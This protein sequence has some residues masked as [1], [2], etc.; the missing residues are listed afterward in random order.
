ME[1]KAKERAYLLVSVFCIAICL[2]LIFCMMTRSPVLVGGTAGGH[3]PPQQRELS[4]VGSPTSEQKRMMVT[5]E[6]FSKM[7]S[8]YLPSGFPA[9]EIDVQISESGS[10]LLS[11]QVER[12]NIEQYLE[13]NQVSL[14]V[15]QRLLMSMMPKAFEL[16]A[17][18]ACTTSDDGGT[19]LIVPETISLNESEVEVGELPA[20][21]LDEISAAA[22]SLL[23]GTGYYFTQI[24]F[25]DGAIELSAGE[26]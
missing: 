22:N 4:E 6:Y 3:L 12:K 15:K 21:L 8:Q 20:V 7:L 9:K 18:F 11:A 17:S 10:I 13:N 19:L 26:A 24:Q 14:N 2:L 23:L 16:S 5:E 1:S 25:I